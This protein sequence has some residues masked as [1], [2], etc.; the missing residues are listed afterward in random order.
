[1]VFI[2]FFILHTLTN[3]KYPKRR[4]A[5]LIIKRKR[6]RK[7]FVMARKTCGLFKLEKAKSDIYSVLTKYISLILN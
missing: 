1:L 4:V 5:T 2:K 3:K 6:K 7:L